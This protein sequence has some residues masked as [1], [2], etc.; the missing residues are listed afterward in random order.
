MGDGRGKMEE[1][2]RGKMGD[3]RMGET[4]KTGDAL[5]SLQLF[6]NAFIISK[7]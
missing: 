1:K 3:G 5:A 2:A 7:P 6:K 4:A